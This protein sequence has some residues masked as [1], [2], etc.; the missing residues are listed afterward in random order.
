M[1]STDRDADRRRYGRAF[2]LLSRILYEEDPIGIAFGDNTDEYEPE[3][4]TIL[5]R[6]AACGSVEEVR[7]VVHEE[8]VRWF[9]EDTAGDPETYAATARRIWEELLPLADPPDDGE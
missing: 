5:P 7:E 8:F 9:E 2:D 4:R 3:V 1:A 6:L